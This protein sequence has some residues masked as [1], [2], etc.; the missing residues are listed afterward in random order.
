[1]PGRGPGRPA[2]SSSGSLTCSGRRAIRRGQSPPEPAPDHDPFGGA[3]TPEQ[4]LV[5]TYNV[6][7]ARELSERIGKAIGA[8]ARAR[9][10]VSNFHSFCHRILAEHSAEAGLAAHPDVLDSIGQILLLRDI[11]SSLPLIYHSGRSNPNQW[12][13][14]F[15]AF[16]NRA[17]DELV[18]PDDFDAYVERER[19]AYE[20]HFGNYADALARI[21]AQGILDVTK[22]V[23]STYADFRRRERADA[24]GEDGAE[25]DIARVAAIA[26]REARRTVSGTGEALHINRF[27]DDQR[28]QIEELAATYVEDGAALEVLRL[29][30]L[31]LV[32]R[33]YQAEL[34][35]RGALDFGEQIAAVTH[36]F[37]RRPNVLRTYQRLFRYILVDEFQDANIAQIELVEM[38]ARTPDRPTNL[39]VVGD[40]DQSI[41]RFRGASF[42]AFAELDRRLGPGD[43][44]KRLRLEE[45]FRSTSRS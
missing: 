6:R 45:N 18:T 15:V 32:Y 43:R 2:S 41:Y 28:A 3:L 29:G 7:A 17:K 37:K 38:L 20:E 34:E 4:I 33:A 27:N 26:N 5:L 42:A 13:D 16:I 8:A 31:A 21:D 40:D 44:P 36:L 39:M 1:M 12:L 14:Q 22:A 10:P 11:R 19:A 30:E 23:R 25:P 35:R 9:L 24:R